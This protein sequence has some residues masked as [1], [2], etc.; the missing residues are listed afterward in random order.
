MRY[1]G[2]VGY[3]MEV[4]NPPGVWKNDVVERKVTGDVLSPGASHSSNGQQLND[5][6]LTQRISIL[7]D[8]FAYT[9]FTNIVYITFMGHKWIVNNIQISRPRLIISLGG[10]YVGN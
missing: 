3:T 4:E 7:A 8:E 9:N 1:S 5:T 10:I 6:L 2:L